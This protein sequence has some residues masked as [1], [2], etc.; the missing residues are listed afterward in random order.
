MND[1]RK[2][3]NKKTYSFDTS[4]AMDDRS[5]F[6][7]P[8]FE[9]TLNEEREEK[10]AQFATQVSLELITNFSPED[11]FDVF[12][13]IRIELER[14][15]RLTVDTMSEELTD[16]SVYFENLRNLIY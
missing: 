9:A 12:N 3:H 5:K 2:D 16:R 15:L 7:K 10:K 13:S 1:E 11:R 14:A 4:M 8:I 6:M